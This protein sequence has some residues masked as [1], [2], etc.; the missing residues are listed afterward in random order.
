LA[1]KQAHPGDSWAPLTVRRLPITQ[2]KPA[3][4]AIYANRDDLLGEQEI[5]LDNE[6]EKLFRELGGIEDR[7]VEDV[8]AIMADQMAASLRGERIGDGRRCDYRRAN[9][10]PVR[11]SADGDG[12]GP[13][14][15]PGM[16]RV[17]EQVAER[18][19]KFLDLIKDQASKDLL[20]R[21][22]AFVDSSRKQI[23]QRV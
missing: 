8:G 17:G 13:R 5:Y 22:L 20:V 16:G 3:N 4:D 15:A 10:R 6:A 2:A 19:E 12:Q 21:T 9:R 14:Q 11:G 23:V 7:G 18:Q 1:E